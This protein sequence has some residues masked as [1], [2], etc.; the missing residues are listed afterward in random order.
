M[1]KAALILVVILIAALG[2]WKI[3]F[4][5]LWGHI[6]GWIIDLFSFD[7]DVECSVFA[8][9]GE[10]VLRLFKD[11]KEFY[12]T[13]KDFAFS[14][15]ALVGWQIFLIFYIP[16]KKWLRS[17]AVNIPVLLILQ[18]LFIGIALPL[19]K[20]SVPWLD[21]YITVLPNFIILVFFFILKDLAVEKPSILKKRS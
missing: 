13:T 8:H 9:K 2:A 7:S 16:F 5:F 4:G 6:L 10:P 19:S 15:L 1:K 14:A 20:Q 12:Q 11:G 3:G 18:S 21:F 17:I